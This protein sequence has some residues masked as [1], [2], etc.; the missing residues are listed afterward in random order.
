MSAGFKN[1]I[2]W[3]RGKNTKS[4]HLLDPLISIPINGTKNKKIKEIKNKIKHKIINFSFFKNE[5]EIVT[6]K[7]NATKTKCFK[8]K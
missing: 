6:T 2:G 1:S 7:L 4:I 8:K 3:K 5:K